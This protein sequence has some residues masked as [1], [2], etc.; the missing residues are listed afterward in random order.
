[1]DAVFQHISTEII[2]FQQLNEP[3][4]CK[5]NGSKLLH[6]I[7]AIFIVTDGR[8]KVKWKSSKKRN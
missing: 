5:M 7:I 6:H 3:P 2:I 1:M 8:K 4:P